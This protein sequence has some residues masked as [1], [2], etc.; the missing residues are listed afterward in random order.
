MEKIAITIDTIFR[1]LEDIRTQYRK[2]LIDKTDTLSNMTSLLVTE[3]IANSQ[4]N[5]QLANI[6]CDSV[7]RL[8]KIQEIMLLAELE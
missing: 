1:R 5:R 2:G 4:D 7:K 6:Q 8:R 3:V